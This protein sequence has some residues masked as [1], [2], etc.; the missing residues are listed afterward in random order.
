MYTLKLFSVKKLD[1]IYTK[2]KKVEDKYLGNCS[3]L[4]RA[5]TK[6]K[7]VF[8]LKHDWTILK[9]VGTYVGVIGYITQVQLVDLGNFFGKFVLAIPPEH[10]LLKVRLFIMAHIAVSSSEE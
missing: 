6:F 8:F 4:S 1:W 5:L 7:P 2:D 9:S 3:M 10:D